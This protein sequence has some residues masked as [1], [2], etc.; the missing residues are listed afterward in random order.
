ML[1]IGETTEYV[2]IPRDTFE[3]L[4]DAK[5]RYDYLYARMEFLVDLIAENVQISTDVV[6]KAINSTKADKVLKK[7][8]D[9]IESGSEDIEQN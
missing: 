3:D 6:L 4:L 2:S 1:E 7:L 9:K 5:S 8:Y